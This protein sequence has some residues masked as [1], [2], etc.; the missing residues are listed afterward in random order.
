MPQDGFSALPARGRIVDVARNR[1]T[2]NAVDGRFEDDGDPLDPIIQQHGVA[3]IAGVVSRHGLRRRAVVAPAIPHLNV[4]RE[5]PGLLY[6]ALSSFD[7]GTS[8]TGG[9][10]G[11]N[12]ANNDG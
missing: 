12:E 2:V 11:T 6:P 5:F 7:P 9:G 3:H 10:D 4:Y 8:Q 1:E